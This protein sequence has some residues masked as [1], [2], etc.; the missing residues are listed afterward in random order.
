VQW[1]IFRVFKVFIEHLEMKNKIKKSVL[2]HSLAIN[3]K[4]CLNL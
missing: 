4:N 2:G 3:A 1:R